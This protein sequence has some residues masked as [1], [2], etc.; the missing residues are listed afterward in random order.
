MRRTLALLVLISLAVTVAPAAAA[1]R[2]KTPRLK[3]F[4]SCAGLISYA[5]RHAPPPRLVLPPRR[6]PDVPVSGGGEDDSGAAPAPVPVTA[7]A[8]DSSTTNVQEAGVDEPDIVKTDGTTVFALTGGRLHSVDA[9]SPLPRKLDAVSI[10]GFGGELLIQGRRALTISERRGRDGAERDRHRQPG[11]D[12]RAAHAQHR[13]RLR[14]RAPARAHRARRRLLGAARARRADPVA[15]AAAADPG[16]GS[17]SAKKKHKPLRARRAGW[18][19]NATLRNR[20]SGRKRKR[21]LVACDDVRR[22]PRF[23]GAGMLTVVTIDLAEG[24]QKLDTDSVMT[25]ADT[26][27]ASPTSLYVATSGGWQRDDTSIHRFDLA[28]DAAPSTARAARCPA[29]CSTSS[30]SPSTRACC[31]PRPPRGSRTTARAT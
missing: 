22:T 25:N 24:L 11:G 17:T 14:Q 10:P 15:A 18:V 7:P 30:R 31:A 12:A 21:A 4:R 9:R 3:A 13:R 23:T 8:P 6:V 27:Y 28:G 29:T 19:P 16:R 2:A 20:R 26:V 1:K 5:R